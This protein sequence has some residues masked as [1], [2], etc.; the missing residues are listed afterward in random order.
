MTVRAIGKLN[1]AG[2]LADIPQ[3]APNGDILSAPIIINLP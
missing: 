2:E 1:G 3:K